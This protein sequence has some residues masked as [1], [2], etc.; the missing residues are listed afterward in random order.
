MKL[1]IGDNGPTVF[2]LQ[3]ALRKLVDPELEPSGVFCAKTET[4]LKLWQQETYVTG[5]IDEPTML[6]MEK[7]LIMPSFRHTMT[8]PEEKNFSKG[9]KGYKVKFIIIH[10]INT[11]LQE[12][13]NIYP[14]F[15]IAYEGSII[16]HINTRDTAWH[17]ADLN[18]QA[19]K[20]INE[21]S[22]GIGLVNIGKFFLKNIKG[23]PL[24]FYKDRNNR[25]TEYDQEMFG[26]ADKKDKE[27]FAPYKKEQYQSLVK[28]VLDLKSY[29]SVET[30]YFRDDISLNP[31]DS[32]K[33]NN[34]PMEE[35]Y[36]SIKALKPIRGD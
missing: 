15:S 26:Y 36:E 9:R 28:L 22:V 13:G 33:V 14:H 23:Q 31:N 3:I 6:L 17:A 5:T 8:I 7:S 19:D 35:F 10:R 16:E 20:W 24:P 32:N 25:D 11:D 27:I 12:K 18:I 1:E 4:A 2:N 21:Q 29:Y 30:V 34:F